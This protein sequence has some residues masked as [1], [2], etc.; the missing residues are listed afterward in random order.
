MKNIYNKSDMY[1]GAIVRDCKINVEL[2][3]FH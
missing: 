3:E 1:V 2:K